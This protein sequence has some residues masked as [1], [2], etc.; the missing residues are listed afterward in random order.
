VRIPRLDWS[1]V[2]GLAALQ[3]QLHHLSGRQR[4][5]A[6]WA[7][8]ALLALAS[9][10]VTL[11]YAF[12]YERMKGKLIDALADKY[13]VT[14]GDVGGG[15]LPGTI[16]FE[17]VVLRPRPTVTGEKTSEIVFDEIVLDLGLDFGLMGALRKKAVFDVEA[18][19]GGGEIQ[20][21]VEISTTL[22]ETHVET[23]GLALANVPGV[24]AAV[25]LPMAGSLDATIDLRL[26]GGKWKNAEGRVAIDCDGCTVGDGV[27]KMSMT[28][29]TS[30]SRRRRA[31]AAAAAWGAQGVTVPRLSLGE[32]EVVVDI[33]KGVG[34][35]KSFAATS[36]DGWL[37]IEGKIEFRDPF[38]NTLFPGCMRFKLSD[39]L[40]QRAPDFGN[41]EYTLSEKV[42]QADGSFAIPTKGKLT[43]LR[44]DVRRKCGG[45]STEDDGG[46]R[47]IAGRPSLDVEPPIP[48]GMPVDPSQVPGVNPADSA[49]EAAAAAA[50]AAAEMPAPGSSG[51]PLDN[52]QGLRDGGAGNVVPPIPPPP[53]DVPPDTQVQRIVPEQPPEDYQQQQQGYQPP[54]PPAYDQPTEIQQQEPNPPPEV[55]RDP[56]D[57]GVD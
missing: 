46:D 14:V 57:R 1:R 47:G 7:G 19:L 33:S 37:K 4:R 45:G 5:I 12:P 43:E 56:E 2:R 52:M 23:E 48:G 34:D 51:P 6:R 44:W 25:G 10:L 54:P 50:R 36:K 53:P 42:R 40:K 16:V 17:D 3:T 15:F 38:P 39:D 9:F 24:A 31:S 41:I 11:K 29:S 32:T 8:M 35:I 26:P 22:F 20:A 18:E 21:E 27:S 13:D 28:P 55:Q 49:E 30:S